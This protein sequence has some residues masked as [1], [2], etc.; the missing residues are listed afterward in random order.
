MS[1][2]EEVGDSAAPGLLHT[3]P[4]LSGPTGPFSMQPA[5][6]PQAARGFPPLALSWPQ[7]T[8]QC[9]FFR[10][11]FLEA[12]AHSLLHSVLTGVHGGPLV[13]ARW[14]KDTQCHLT[15]ND[16]SV[17]LTESEVT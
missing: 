1:L 16:E 8:V 11:T 4:A 3:L 9:G 2:E 17:F 10:P 7:V 6:L 12:Q 13:F 14:S 15:C 5:W